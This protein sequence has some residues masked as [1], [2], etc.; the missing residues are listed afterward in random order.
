MHS[1]FARRGGS[2]L[3]ARLHRDKLR[4]TILA[5]FEALRFIAHKI[6]FFALAR[7]DHFYQHLR[8]TNPRERIVIR[9][10]PHRRRG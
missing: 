8:N 7:N 6:R 10:E 5:A 9:N 4:Q 3:V 2:S 1:A